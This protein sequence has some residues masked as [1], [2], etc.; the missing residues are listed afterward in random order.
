MSIVV[1]WDNPEKTAIVYTITGRWTWDEF[2]EALQQERAMLEAEAG[3]RVNFIV[4]MEQGR[5]L[6]DNALSHFARMPKSSHRKA[7]MMVLVGAGGFVQALMNI[8]GRYPGTAAQK[9][10]AVP[11]MEAARAFLAQH[12]HE[13]ATSL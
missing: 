3:E 7:G 4:N 13:N 8:L 10:V 2:Y 6:P 5:M 11:N 12:E 1:S 9:I